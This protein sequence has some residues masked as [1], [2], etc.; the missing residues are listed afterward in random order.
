MHRYIAS[1]K[2]I[3]CGLHSKIY[4]VSLHKPLLL[5]RHYYSVISVKS[6]GKKKRSQTE[7][8][9]VYEEIPLEKKPVIELHSNEAYGHISQ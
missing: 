6:Q 7:I 9:P 1:Y 4:V 3:R 5:T 2:S 8:P